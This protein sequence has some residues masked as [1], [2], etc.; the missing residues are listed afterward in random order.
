MVYFLYK[1][2]LVLYVDFAFYMDLDWWRL[3]INDFYVLK[4]DLVVTALCGLVDSR[5]SSSL[6]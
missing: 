2:F 5:S 4:F 3:N 6:A 1:F